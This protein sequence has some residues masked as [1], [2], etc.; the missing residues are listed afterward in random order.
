M[1]KR[2]RRDVVRVS[3]LLIIAGFSWF[4]L[5]QSQEQLPVVVDREGKKPDAYLRNF[6]I[7][8]MSEFGQPRYRLEAIYMEHFPQDDT[9][10]LV[11][12]LLTVFRPDELPWY[13]KSERGVLKPLE[14]RVLLL[15]DVQ[16]EYLDDKGQ[17]LRVLTKDLII[18]P[19][20]QY[21]ETDQPVTIIDQHGITRAV[22]LRAFLETGRLSLLAEVR[23]EYDLSKK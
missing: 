6:I 22:G 23:G 3:V 2:R 12:P 16:M 5:R 8:T 14:D 15:G 21:A 9:S 18:H 20:Q 1:G 10:E 4:L 11:K 19:D 7:T 13:V 17:S